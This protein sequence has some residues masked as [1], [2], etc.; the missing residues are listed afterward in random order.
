MNPVLFGIVFSAIMIYLIISIITSE[1]NV[2][3]Q[4]PVAKAGKVSDFYP[5]EETLQR[6]IPQFINVAGKR[7]S[8]LGYVVLYVHG[9]SMK[10]YKIYDKQFIFVKTVGC[11]NNIDNHPVLVFRITDPEQDDAEYKLRKFICLIE[12]LDSVDWS[13]IYEQNRER[14]SISKNEFITQCEEKANKIK[15]DVEGKVVLSETFDR[16]TNKDCYSLHA[17]STIYGIVKYAA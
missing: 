2:P 16:A 8:L 3:V 6:K 1:S 17:L 10:K 9:E 14:I 13:D 12:K 15:G 4:I 11:I 5:K 7:I